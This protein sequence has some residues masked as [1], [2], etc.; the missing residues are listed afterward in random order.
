[1]IYAEKAGMS[2]YPDINPDFEPAVPEEHHKIYAGVQEGEINEQQLSRLLDRDD[3]IHYFLRLGG[4]E[5]RLEEYLRKGGIGT[6]I[7]IDLDDFKGFNDKNGHPV[8]NDLLQLAAEIVFEQTRTH[9]P[10]PEVA[11]RRVNRRPEF[12]LLA[13]GGDEFFVYL[14]GAR[15][16]SA[17]SA[18]I[19]IRRSI[20]NRVKERFPDYDAEQTMSLGLAYPKEG[21]SAREL[22]ERADQA[23]YRAKRGKL[24]GIVKDSI[25][26]SR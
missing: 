15:I 8:G 13:R 11:E 16:P 5:R 6:L 19:R 1:M 17:I 7:A 24:T 10:P 26:T 14:V 22:F 9:V 20:G 3:L 18:A 4:L 12:D 2:Q 23:L 25:V 21:E